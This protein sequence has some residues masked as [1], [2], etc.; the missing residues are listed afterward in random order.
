M[1]T[2]RV[3]AH[4]GW[5]VGKTLHPTSS[6]EITFSSSQ[7]FPRSLASTLLCWTFPCFF[8]DFCQRRPRGTSIEPPSWTLTMQSDYCVLE[9]RYRN[10]IDGVIGFGVSTT[11]KNDFEIRIIIILCHRR[12]WI[13]MNEKQNCSLS[14]L[15]NTFFIFIIISTI[16]IFTIIANAIYV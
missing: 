16:F 7:L 6:G 5:M 12:E 8:S 10:K 14:Y 2:R 4:L 3:P 9:C 15:K 1:P 11:I 13:E